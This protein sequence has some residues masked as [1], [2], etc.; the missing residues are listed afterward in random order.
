MPAPRQD[1]KERTLT[2]SDITSIVLASEGDEGTPT[3]TNVQQP[4]LLLQGQLLADESELV[5]LK[6]LERLLL[7]DVADDTGSVNP[8][9]TGTRSSARG[10]FMAVS[11]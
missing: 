3:T 6:L 1:P 8:E 9:Q 2:S 4:V 7:V 5:V 10:S 11:S